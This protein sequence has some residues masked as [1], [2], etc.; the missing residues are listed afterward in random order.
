MWILSPL[1]WLLLAGAWLWLRRDRSPFPF[2]EYLIA[3]GLGRLVI[4]NWRSNPPLL[5]PLTNA[6]L[7]A[8]VCL[9][10]GVLGLA[11]FARRRPQEL[12]AS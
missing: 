11:Y 4:E 9:A 8:L 5:G 3:Q 2:G 12:P 6:Q 7:V 1:T 10:I